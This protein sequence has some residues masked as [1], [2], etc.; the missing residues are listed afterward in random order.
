MSSAAEATNKINKRIMT[1]VVQSDKMDKTIV[2]MVEYRK[3][4][5]LYKKYVK[6][7]KKYKAHDEKNQAGTGDKVKI[8]ESKPISKNKCW[9]LVEV[10]E[11]AK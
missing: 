9:K 6:Q 8:I 3:L 5:P 4:H 11:K 2:V 10:I 7:S 1:G